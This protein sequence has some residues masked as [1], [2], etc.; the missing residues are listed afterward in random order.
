MNERKL[1]TYE[2]DPWSANKNSPTNT[3]HHILEV[4]ARGADKNQDQS[5]LEIINMFE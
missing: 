5:G 4:E 2:P 1:Q 3:I